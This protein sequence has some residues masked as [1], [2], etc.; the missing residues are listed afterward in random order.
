MVVS[1]EEK[2]ITRSDGSENVLGVLIGCI[3]STLV[4]IPETPYQQRAP[5]PESTLLS[6]SKKA[7][8]LTPLRPSIKRQIWSMPKPVRIAHTMTVDRLKGVTSREIVL[9]NIV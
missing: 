8:V 1:L 9:R 2:N 4:A 5:G 3:V 7:Q 6:W